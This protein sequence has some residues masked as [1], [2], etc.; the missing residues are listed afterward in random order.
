M[1]KQEFTSYKSPL[2]ALTKKWWSTKTT[3]VLSIFILFQASYA[4]NFEIDKIISLERA[5]FAKKHVQNKSF[6]NRN[7]D[8]NYYRLNL[9]IEPAIKYVQGS[10]T[11][12]FSIN[13][14]SLQSLTF[15]I[16][17][18]LQIDSIKHRN[19]LTTY[20]HQDNKVIITTNDTLFQNELDSITIY[21]Q[22]V[23]QSNG[24]GTF[25]QDSYNGQDSIIWTLSQPYGASEWW[26]CQNNLADKADSIE[27]LITTNLGQA[28]ATNGVLLNIDTIGS[29]HQFHYKSKYP[30]AS[31]LVAIA[32][33]NYDIY[34]EKY[35]LG[36]DSLAI[37]H[38]LYPT[39]T[40][41]ESNNALLPFLQMFDSLF[42][43]YPF[44][45]EKYGHASF[46]FG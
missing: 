8:V 11:S 1:K 24:L 32:V 28:V 15:D 37:E 33:T 7:I 36:T 43:T 29:F 34:R 4:Q 5:A 42:G 26:P 2:K 23:P 19:S 38:F 20:L 45:D 40:L 12:Y 6:E 3:L 44:I 16:S 25:V 31:Y 17:D 41:T 27:I 10:L 21:Y 22:G 39:Q 9:T 46:T 30:I 18:S 14:D 35:A 13:E